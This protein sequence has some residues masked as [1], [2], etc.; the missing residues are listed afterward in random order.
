[1]LRSI[2]RM[3]LDWGT[4]CLYGPNES[5]YFVCLNHSF[6]LSLTR[7]RNPIIIRSTCW[8]AT[9]FTIS[10]LFQHSVLPPTTTAIR[11]SSFRSSNPVEPID[12]Y[13]QI[14]VLKNPPEWKYVERILR[15]PQVPEPQPKSEYPSGWRPQTNLDN[16]YYVA[17]TKNHMIPAY[18]NLY[19]RGQRKVTKLRKIQGDIW[20]LER[21]LR[22]C[23]E[24]RIGK[25]IATRVNELSGQIWFKGDYATIVTDFLI[26]KGLWAAVGRTGSIC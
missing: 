16:P 7:T 24:K 1:M 23:I 9:K 26:K 25:K 6:V 11:Y 19:F 13:P 15:K 22:E 10:I 21:E 20:L 18:L 14:E 4:F 5:H 17:R 3:R 12:E 2:A 8:P